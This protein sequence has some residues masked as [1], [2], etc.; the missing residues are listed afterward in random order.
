MG[1]VSTDVYISNTKLVTDHVYLWYQGR[2]NKAILKASENTRANEQHSTSNLKLSFQ[3]SAYDD[4]NRKLDNAM[5]K[6]C[7]VLPI[8][9]SKYESP[10]SRMEVNLESGFSNKN[11]RRQNMDDHQQHQRKKFK[12]SRCWIL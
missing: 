12:W 2:H 3:F 4:Q 1:L 5:I 7:G 11:K 6:E 9:S 10:A 8:Y